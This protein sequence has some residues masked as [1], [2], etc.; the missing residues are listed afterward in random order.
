MA[1][2]KVA[3]RLKALDVG[4]LPVGLHLDG[5]G[6]FLQVTPNGRSW[7]YRFTSPTMV[8][9][10]ESARKGQPMIRDM[11]L[12]PVSAISLAK[13]RELASD[14]R[15]LAKTGT[16]PME[17][18]KASREQA[19]MEQARRITFKQATA[20]YIDA[21]RS[22][23]DND[24]SEKQ[25]NNT[26]ATYIHPTVGHLYADEITSDHICEALKPI[27]HSKIAT[28]RRVRSRV[29]SIIDREIAGKRR[30]AE[31][32][33]RLTFIESQLGKQAGAEGHHAALPYTEI[34][35]FMEKLRAED[36]LGARAL[37]LTILCATRTTE[38]IGARW[39][40][41]DLDAGN[42][43]IPAERMKGK[44]GK[45]RPHTVPLSKAA[46]RV[47]ETLSTM[48]LTADPGAFVFP[49]AAKK[50]SRS[51]KPAHLSNMA[52]LATLERMGREDLTTH[53]FRSAFKDW[54]V[55][56]KH[57]ID[58]ID[59][60]SEA[61][62][63]H[64]IK[65]ETQAAYERGEKLELRRDLMELWGKACMTPPADPKSKVVPITKGRRQRATA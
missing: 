55:E 17:A 2:K 46:R 27:W 9:G 43:A 23:W 12:G 25:W 24:K 49:G 10:P 39:K 15:E 52:M 50:G 26:L 30:T 48:R 37:E 4:R 14:A 34:G 29:E 11:G 22:S 41:F 45:R 28:A 8:Y 32:P 65:D 40:E 38:T 57:G 36:G 62:L 56:S 58:N 54:A 63:A 64:K 6:L 13:A 20:D 61:A 18:R 5:L 35:S 31:N 16:D 59:K 7:F 51:R 53:G 19:R 33:A 42:W 47:I 44:K 1:P 3:N 60:I 21:N